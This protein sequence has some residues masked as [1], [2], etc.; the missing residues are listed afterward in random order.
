MTERK[1]AE[2]FAPGEFIKDA[3]EARG[4]SQA[5]LAEIIG[6]QPS[7][8]T[9]LINGKRSVTAEI[10]TALGD[11]FETSAQYWLNLEN[12][13][14]LERVK[15]KGDVISRRARLYGIAPIKEMVKRHWLENS[16]NVDVLEKRVMQ[17]F[18]IESLNDEIRLSHVAR[19]G[20]QEVSSAQMA[21]LFRVKQLAYA[22]HAKNFSDQ[23]FEEAL[24]KLK[25]LLLSTH[26][27][28]NVPR[29]LAEA[30]IRFLIVEHLPRTKIDGVTIWLNN[31]SPVI[32]L[33]LRYD[34]IDS[35]WFT[36]AHELGHVKNRD[37]M[38][39]PVLDTDIYGEEST[40][41]E[42]EPEVESRANWFATELLITHEAINDFIA[43]TSP[44]YSTQ[45][46]LRFANNI[47]IHPGIVI[48]QLQHRREVFWSSYRQMLDRI[49]DI[50]IQSS[51]TDGWGCTASILP[52][53][54]T[55][56]G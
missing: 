43:R 31:R 12:I 42:H 33:S 9:E 17:F 25:R 40:S 24:E 15:D 7:V 53:K 37:G 38:K 6:R 56:D 45:R 51:L 41:S 27:A 30:G 2:V 16:E 55:Q 22:V 23:L 21:W 26:E 52:H 35:F 11:A 3:L 18:E 34:R 48:G 28:R 20:A 50:V 49:R 5:E 4:W 39:T 44:L 32:A 14:Q 29:I 13:Y 46:I 1:V 47:R 19:K 10:A 54:E 8:V 36:L